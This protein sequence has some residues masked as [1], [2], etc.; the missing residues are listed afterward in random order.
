MK[1]L[2]WQPHNL[3]RTIIVCFCL[4]ML[5][6]LWIVEHYK[7]IKYQAYFKEKLHAAHWTAKAFRTVRQGRLHRQIAINRS[8]DPQRSGLIGKEFSLIT[9]DSGD[10]AVKQSTINPNI[11]ALFIDWLKQLGAKPGDAVAVNMTGSFPALD[12]A[13]LAAFKTLSIKPLIT[14]SASASQYGANIPGYS[15]VDMYH[16]L[17][18]KKLFDFPVLGVSIGGGRDRGYGMDALGV[19]AL[20]EVIHKYGYNF[21]DSSGTIDGI[22]KRMAL[23]VQAAD[24]KPILAFVNVGGNMASIGLK[25]LGHHTR[26]SSHKSIRS[27]KTGVVDKLPIY[28]INTDSVAVRFLEKGVPVINVHNISRALLGKYKFPPQ[29]TRPVVVGSGQMFYAKE[30][31]TWLAGF[32]LLLDIGVFA[33]IAVYSKKYLIRYKQ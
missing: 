32:M 8:L 9:S 6:G 26:L 30:Y 16:E 11:A 7:I 23:Y 22:D 25:Q 19:N 13:M 18:R 5:A 27:L 10:L 29:P 12:I 14:F 21:L 24:G 15:W 31:S 17:T 3:P 33:G 20:T 2:Y 28:L 4:F 1:K